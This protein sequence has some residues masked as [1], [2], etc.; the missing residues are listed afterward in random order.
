MDMTGEHRINLPQDLV[1]AGLNDAAVLKA[2]IPGCEELVQDGEGRFKGRVAA[3]IGPVKAKFSGDATLSDIDPPNGYVLTG[4]GSGGAAGMVK[5]SATVKLSTD[6][7][8]TILRFEA[9]AQVAGKLAQ[10]GSR[11]VDMAAKKMADEFFANFAA[12]MEPVPLSETSEEVLESA[13]EPATTPMPDLA[14]SPIP[15]PVPDAAESSSQTRPGWL[16]WAALILIVMI[17]AA[18]YVVTR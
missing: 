17:A 18:A 13:L 10:I 8:V 5:G 6:G 1:W 9:K 16:I 15:S 12:Q 14:P 3:S 2:S 11:L 7:D 4:T